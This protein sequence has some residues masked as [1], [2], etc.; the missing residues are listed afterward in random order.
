MTTAEF[1]VATVELPRAQLID[2][3]LVV[4]V[5]SPLRRHQKIVMRLAHQHWAF[6]AAHPGAGELALPQDIVVDD[7]NVFQPDLY[8]VPDGDGLADHERRFEATPPPLVVEVLSP[9][10]RPRDRGAKRRGY[11]RIGVA[12]LWSVDADAASVTVQ[13]PD[14]TSSTHTTTLTTPLV[15]GWVVD[16]EELFRP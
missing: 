13:R 11:A 1:F 3:E 12:E 8:W 5:D 7:R 4:P 10:T 16:V 14:G 2:G 15:A 9:S 6:A